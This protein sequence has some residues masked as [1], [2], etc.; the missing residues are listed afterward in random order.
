MAFDPVKLAAGPESLFIGGTGEMGADWIIFQIS[1]SSGDFSSTP[2]AKLDGAAGDPAVTCYYNF[3]VDHKVTI[4]PG[5]PITANG[6]YGVFAPEMSLYML[7][8]QGTASLNWK[9]PR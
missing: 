5:I 1:G 9:V 2:Q 8:T 6:V 3:L 4:A 7:T